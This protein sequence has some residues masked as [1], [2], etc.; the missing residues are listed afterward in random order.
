V[1]PPAAAGEADAPWAA[2]DDGELADVGELGDA[3]EPDDE[4]AASNI[5]AEVP[6][7]NPNAAAARRRRVHLAPRSVTDERTV[8][9]G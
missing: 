8:P 2:E 5:T 1:F 7:P 6:T 9:P 3:V 4:Q